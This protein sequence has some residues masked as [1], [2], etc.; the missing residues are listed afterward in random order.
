MKLEINCP[1]GQGLDKDPL[2]PI[3]ITINYVNPNPVKPKTSWLSE[4]GGV[5]AFIGVAKKVFTWFTD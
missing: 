3:H 2:P 4:F 5:L 1:A